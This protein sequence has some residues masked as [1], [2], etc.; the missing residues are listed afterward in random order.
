VQV[1][2]QAGSTVRQ[3]QAISGVHELLKKHIMIPGLINMRIVGKMATYPARSNVL[4]LSVSSI[5]EQLDHLVICCNQ[6][7]GIPRWMLDHPKI[8]ARTPQDDL[9]DTGKFLCTDYPSDYTFY[10]D[11]DIIYPPNYVTHT[12]DEYLRLSRPKSAVGYHGSW[13]KKP[14]FGFHPKRFKKWLGFAI[15]KADPMWYREWVP[16]A[17]SLE[18][19]IQVEQLGTGVMAIP[20]ELVPDFN[21]FKGSEKFVD[22]RFAKWCFENKIELKCLRREEEWLKSLKTDESIYDAFT[23]NTPRYVQREIYTYASHLM[24]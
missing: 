13:Y 11:D 14:L 23:K 7:T 6:S 10:L 2:S 18:R 16:Y 24:L 20:T 4:F 19:T 5:I 8:D 3:T 12:I 22:V 1:Q 15:R 21:Y 9:K 17:S